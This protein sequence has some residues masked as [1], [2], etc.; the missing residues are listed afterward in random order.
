[1][2]LGEDAAFIG[3]PFCSLLPLNKQLNQ[4]QLIPPYHRVQI[5]PCSHSEFE[6]NAT[7]SSSAHCAG[8]P[9]LFGFFRLQ[10]IQTFMASC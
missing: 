9:T 3:L 1:M 7:T 8:K 5:L 6:V 4:Y 10:R 2:G